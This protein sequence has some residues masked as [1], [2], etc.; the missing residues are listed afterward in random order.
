MQDTALVPALD[1]LMD[2][3]RRNL[4]FAHGHSAGHLAGVV[5]T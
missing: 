4:P 2:V 5:V 1:D 3:A